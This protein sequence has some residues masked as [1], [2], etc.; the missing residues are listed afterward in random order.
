MNKKLKKKL[1]NALKRG[2]KLEIMVSAKS[3]IPL[4]PDCVFYNVHKLMKK[5]ADIWVYE[6]G[7]HHTKIIMVDG[8]FCTVGSAN[9]NSRSLSWDYEANAVIIDKNTTKELDVM[10]END[11]KNSFYLTEKKWDEIRSPWKKFVGWFANILSPF[12]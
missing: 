12:L 5:G 3:D 7:F 11:K 4:T 1:K 2:V 8:L 9:L 10:F 6:P